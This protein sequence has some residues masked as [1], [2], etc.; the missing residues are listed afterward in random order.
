MFGGGNSIQ[1]A[2]VFGIRIGVEPSWF[3]VLF[4]II[5]LLTGYYTDVGFAD[6]TAFTLAVVS[7]LAFFLSVL[8]HELGHAVVALRNGIGI[9][10]ID[11]W[12]FGGVAKMNRDT[13]SA[14]VE[15]RVAAAGPFVTLLIAAACYGIGALIAGGGEAVDAIRFDSV[16]GEETL[17]VLGYLTSINLLLLVFNLIPGFPLDGGRIARAVAWKI[18]GDRSRATRFAARLGR[19]FSFLMIAGGVLIVLSSPD[20]LVSGVWLGFVGLFLGQAARQAEAQ[21]EVTS[22]IEGLR[23][24]DVMDDQPVGIPASLGID[25]A[26]DEFFLRYR[27]PWFPVV[28]EAGRFTGLVTSESVN[29][30]LES[31]RATRTVESVMA[32]DTPES[33]EGGLRV[34]LDEPLEALLGREVLQRLGAIVAVDPEGR[35]RGVVTLDQVRRALQPVRS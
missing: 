2:R 31:E 34:G 25:R 11:L 9:A 13:D 7:A 20:N 27:Y 16:A 21:T 18:T 12:M 15:F 26:L 4:L 23:V 30:V 19:G 8:L 22:R 1:L 3:L 14:G 5:Y 33:A 32:P 29:A 28:D 10:G 24:A 35:L 6:G 17:A